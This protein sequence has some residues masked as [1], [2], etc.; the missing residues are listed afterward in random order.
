MEHFVLFLLQIGERGANLSGGQRQRVSLARALYS[1]RPVI[2]LDDP[3]SAVDACVGSHV[4]HKAIMGLSKGKTV[5]F[6]THQLQVK[7]CL[8]TSNEQCRTADAYFSSCFRF[9][10]NLKGP[11][12]AH[13]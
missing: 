4:F 1:E 9:F 7:A 10:N 5:L 3:L 2:L 8:Y 6:V 12:S 13:P 11:V